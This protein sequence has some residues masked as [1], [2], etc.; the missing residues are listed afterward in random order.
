[1]N[2]KQLEISEVVETAILACIGV[3]KYGGQ[4]QSKVLKNDAV[5]KHGA[6]PK[7]V[8]GTVKLFDRADVKEVESIVSKMRANFYF[9]TSPWRD[10]GWRYCPTESFG[11]M[12]EAHEPLAAE[13]RTAVEALVARRDEL[14][15]AYETGVNSELA[16]ERPFPTAD[17]LRELFDCHFK[18]DIIYQGGDVRLRG[19]N[20]A[21]V[22]GIKRQTEESLFDTMKNVILDVIERVRIEA[23]HVAKILDKAKPVVH[24][25]LTENLKKTIASLEALNTLRNPLIAQK[26][27]ELR[28]IAEVGSDKL[29]SSKE[30]REAAVKTCNSILDDLQGFTP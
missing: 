8:G 21:Q 2:T 1:M 14:A 4:H 28:E 12:K 16:M 5:A 23:L 29:K 22:A 3:S 30:A 7:R 19:L 6:D 26:L 18:T 9:Y 11:P 25:S 17:Q 20:D 13:F 27:D 10:D 24:K 15:A